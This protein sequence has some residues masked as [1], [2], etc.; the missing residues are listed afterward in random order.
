MAKAPAKKVAKKPASS[1]R[2]PIKTPAKPKAS[3]PAVSLLEYGMRPIASIRPDPRNARRHSDEQIDGIVRSIKR[4]G[5]PTPIL[6]LHNGQIVAGEGRW[7]SAK[8]MGL[9]E[10]P[11]L[12]APKGWSAADAKAYA[13]AD[14]QLGDESEWNE[15]VLREELRALETSGYDLSALGF[16]DDRLEELLRQQGAQAPGDFPSFDENIETTHQCP[17][18]GY[19]WSGKSGA[20]ETAAEE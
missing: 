11:T 17:S 16:S 6:V 10:V 12:A 9:R 2:K 13:L 1:T 7:L 14:N 18:C 3:G 5:F 20:D 4:F 15:A 19:Q 8:K